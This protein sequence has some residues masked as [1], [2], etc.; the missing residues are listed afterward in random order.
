ME[1]RRVVV[2]TLLVFTTPAGVNAYA[3]PTHRGL[4]EVTI[5]AYERLHGDAFSD[6][7]S[8]LVIRGAGEEDAHPRYANHFYDPINGRG[9]SGW[10]G[11]P[12][13]FITHPS[14]QWA[15]DTIAQ[16]QFMCLVK[17]KKDDR[18]CFL[19]YGHGYE[20][21]WFSSPMDF[22]WDRA[23]YEYVW[24]DKERGVE[25]LGHVI[26]LI[27]DAT[28]PAH[29]RN[30]DHTSGDTYEDYTARFIE[31]NIPIPTSVRPPT[32]S[33]IDDAFERVAS[34]TNIN[35][36]SDDTVS[37]EYPR[38]A[39]D[40]LTVQNGY[41]RGIDNLKIA[42]VRK[43]FK[44]GQYKNELSVDEDVVSDLWPHLS[45]KAVEA[46]AGVIDL[47]FRAAEEEKRTGRLKAMNISQKDKDRKETILKTFNVAKL[48]YGSSLTQSDVNELLND[49]AGQAGAAAVAL[50]GAQEVPPAP[51]PS[52]QN[53]Q[54]TSAEPVE[55]TFAPTESDAPQEVASAL[56]ED[57]VA[58]Q[59]SQQTQVD[60]PLYQQM[61]PVTP[62]FGGGGGVSSVGS[63]EV[64]EPEPEPT[65]MSL[66]IV[67]PLAGEFF[68][69]S[70]ISFAGTTEADAVVS[71]ESGAL[72]ASTTADASGNWVA[73][74]ALNEGAADVT[75]TAS[76]TGG[77]R[78]TS[79]SR[80]IFV[81]L[82]P[83]ATATVTLP[84]CEL[85]LSSSFC[86]LVTQDVEVEW[87][88]VPDA[89]YY[90]VI[91]NGVAYA[92]T[93]A[94]SSTANAV[95]VASTT[96]AV[97]SY[98]A[99][100]N[101]A[102]ST[103]EYVYA[104]E[105]PLIINEIAWAGTDSLAT[106]EWIELLNTTPFELDMAHVH[107]SI[108]GVAAALSGIASPNG[109]YLVED[110]AEATS[111]A[112]DALFDMDLPDAGAVVQLADEVGTVFDSTPDIATCGGWCA[113][114]VAGLIG[115][116]AQK[117]NLSANQSMERVDSGAEGT[118][119]SSWH[120]NDTYIRTSSSRA[121]DSGGGTVYG[122][123]GMSNGAGLPDAGWS[124][125]GDTLDSSGGTYNPTHDFCTYL[126]AFISTEANRYGDIFK[127]T[128]GSS[129]LA[130]G[131]SLAKS[132]Q[133][134]QNDT[135]LVAGALAG[136]QFFVAMYE[137]RTGPAFSG[138]LT[139]FRNYMQTGVGSPPHSNYVTIPWTYAP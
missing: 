133:S 78:A 60:A 58:E 32:Y 113:G 127:G 5:K 125:G 53:Q 34:Y 111:K 44:N 10:Y 90:A 114:S 120:S 102:T 42:R 41:A 3:V 89:A 36:V 15:Q 80:T 13:S 12:I 97:V 137:I 43:S 35:F 95:F 4:S 51:S 139:A 50:G 136:E 11:A 26:H 118:L 49:S 8:A 37:K 126:S 52:P 135:N 47:F 91:I 122:T 101:S 88:L 121:I 132:I 55:Q 22:S 85:S 25:S 70:T 105:R 87:A 45:Q 39:I 72:T 86:L 123:P 134:S 124:C 14:K 57:D 33:T 119:A 93:S 27:Q 7:E 138:D 21:K 108:D 130:T 30:D 65:P 19:G 82:T 9:L 40:T 56:A 77:D 31:G 24:G 69:T 20:D 68:A 131:H 17:S 71:L 84:Q 100:G 116:S 66:S 129:T 16:A 81:D 112:H 76:D 106:D 79:T 63:E 117:G 28:V 59:V 75:V 103:S 6:A 29:V 104:V 46:G 110:R 98:D 109:L 2:L 128:V 54:P 115:T 74:L 107:L 94:T 73:F 67:S 64:S 38:P 99:A 96:V 48:L 18:G 92:T 61:V 62:G 1:T 23:V 83:P